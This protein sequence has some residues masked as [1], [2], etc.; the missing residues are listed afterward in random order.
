M[1][2][3]LGHLY[4][5]IRLDEFVD[6]E[7]KYRSQSGSPIPQILV[8][9]MQAER[10]HMSGQRFEKAFFLYIQNRFDL[11]LRILDVVSF[12]NV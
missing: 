12:T 3:R 1:S 6:I 5:R 8:N 2:I 10:F 7:R 11:Q 4:E 9:K